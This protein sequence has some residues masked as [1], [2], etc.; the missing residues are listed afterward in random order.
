[1]TDSKFKNEIREEH[2]F[3]KKINTV[4]NGVVAGNDG[5]GIALLLANLAHGWHCYLPVDYSLLRTS[6]VYVYV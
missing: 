5:S 2:E 6:L 3:M 4:C 1:M